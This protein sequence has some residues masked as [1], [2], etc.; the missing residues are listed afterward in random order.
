M[1]DSICCSFVECVVGNSIDFVIFSSQLLNAK[2]FPEVLKCGDYKLVLKPIDDSPSIEFDST[3]ED[4]GNADEMMS[5]LHD[6]VEL[7]ITCSRLTKM[8]LKLSTKQCYGYNK[9]KNFKR[10]EN[11]R[12]NIAGGHVWCHHHEYQRELYEMNYSLSAP[13]ACSYIPD[14]WE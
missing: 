12:R 4:N 3:T 5:V 7:K 8:R 10:C 1:Q 6:D 2:S 13:S 9:Y 11:R 14:W